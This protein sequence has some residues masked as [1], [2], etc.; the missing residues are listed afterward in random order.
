[1]QTLTRASE[2]L[3]RRSRLSAALDAR[4]SQG[5]TDAELKAAI[6]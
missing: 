2:E 4:R 6:S 3:F 5:G 1:M